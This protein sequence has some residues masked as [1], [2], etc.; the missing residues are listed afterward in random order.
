MKVQTVCEHGTVGTVL[1]QID[2]AIALQSAATYAAIVCGSRWEIGAQRA[3]LKPHTQWV[4]KQETAQAKSGCDR[5]KHI[6][7]LVLGIAL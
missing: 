5:N 4:E 3:L 6:P 2:A 1:A 7:L